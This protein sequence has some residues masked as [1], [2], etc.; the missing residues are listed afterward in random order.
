MRV[1]LKSLRYTEKL[2]YYSI[3]PQKMYILHTRTL[4][5]RT[6]LFCL[7]IHVIRKSDSR[8]QSLVPFTESPFF[9]VVYRLNTSKSV[10]AII[11]SCLKLFSDTLKC[12]WCCESVVW[13]ILW[14]D[15]E[16][17]TKKKMKNWFT[18][19]DFVLQGVFRVDVCIGVH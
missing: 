10:I 16:E 19:Y 2:T 7:F 1:N 6:C 13:D 14:N 3:Y 8:S 4:E 17:H 15:V 5:T 11:F 9:F 18:L 12:F